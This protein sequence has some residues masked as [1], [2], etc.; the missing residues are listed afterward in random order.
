MD[1][2]AAVEK[3]ELQELA[4]RG[5]PFTF[6]EKISLLDYCQTDVDALVGLLPK[7]VLPERGNG[8]EALIGLAL[9]QL[10]ARLV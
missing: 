3:T 1:S 5:G 8:R 9:E 4:M 10:A 7:T 6:A 2:I